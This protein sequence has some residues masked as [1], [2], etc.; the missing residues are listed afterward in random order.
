MSFSLVACGSS[1][2]TTET[3]TEETTTEETTTEDAA[4]EEAT[5]TEETAAE[6]TTDAEETTEETA[7]AALKIAIV[8]SPSGVDDGSFNEDNYNGILSFIEA[9]PDATVTPVQ[10]TTGDTAAAVQAVADI[11]A[12][13]D[14]IVCCGFQFAG[15]STVAQ[16]NPDVKFILVD[17]FPSDAEGNTVEVENIYAMC[18][19][20]QESG[21]FAGMAAALETTTNKV[22]VVNGIAY[23]SNVNYQYGF[24]CGVKY[25]N[26]TEGKS[27]EVVELPSYAG[28][29]V[30]G[31]NVGGNYIGSFADEATG[32][33]VGNALIEEG[34]DIVFVAAGASGNGTLTAVKEAEGVKF[35]GCDVDQYDDG[36]NGDSNVVLTSA[37]KVMH[38]NVER[39]LTAIADGSFKG[40]NVTLQA[41]TDS[42]GYVSEEGRCQLSAETIEKIDA[43]YEQVKS[44]A[45]VPAA[46]FNGI[47]PED[48]TW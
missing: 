42:T 25:V 7:G 36:A 1:A 21:F 33:V 20:E 48:F 31:A 16:E 15:I 11:V 26:E 43:A 23:P 37:L 5:T 28:T 17:S 47:T 19:A 4:T 8:S 41:D 27:V 18:F 10:E 3:T 44:G 29:D 9:N 39:A 12:D 40:G 14:V 6:E 46:N 22:A 2:D 45:I 35:I 30:T 38:L 24:E 34:V 32:K 13:Y